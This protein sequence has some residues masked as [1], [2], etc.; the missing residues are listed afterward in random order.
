MPADTLDRVH[1]VPGVEEAD[2][3]VSADVNLLDPERQADPLQRPADDRRHH[4]AEAL[5]PAD[6]HGGRPAED[7]TTRSCIDK[8]TADK[9]DFGV[10]DKVTVAGRAPTKEYTVS[11]IAT[12][13]DSENLAGSRLVV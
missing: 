7:A 12:L 1:S 8:G 11:G 6:L 3:S 4:R 5:R 9:Y 2:G 10:G 13:G